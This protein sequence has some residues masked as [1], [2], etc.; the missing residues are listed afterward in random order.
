M[1]DEA[2][3]EPVVPSAPATERGNNEAQLTV[4]KNFLELFQKATD[5]A[6]GNSRKAVDLAHKLSDRLG[7]AE[8]RVAV[9]E[10]Q[11]AK[12]QTEVE[13]YREKSKR[14]ED[15]LGKISGEIQEQVRKT[16]N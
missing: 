5:L 15:W 14:A 1:S 10:E 6:G 4:G 8:S 11:V 9:L 7:L 3:S 13:F 12:L 2:N 16:I